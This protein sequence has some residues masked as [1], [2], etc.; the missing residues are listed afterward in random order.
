MYVY[1]YSQIFHSK[2][3][4]FDKVVRNPDSQILAVPMGLFDYWIRIRIHSDSD[5]EFRFRFTWQIEW[6]R[7]V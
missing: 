7:R 5:S 2:T 3:P 4:R 6:L 1:K